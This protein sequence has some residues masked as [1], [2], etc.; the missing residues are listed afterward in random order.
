MG[1]ARRCCVVTP[2]QR[3]AGGR[4]VKAAG[5]RAAGGVKG[6]VAQRA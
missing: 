3:A 6:G 4:Q 2:C 5:R 1:G